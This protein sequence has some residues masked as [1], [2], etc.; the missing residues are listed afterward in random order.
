MNFLHAF[1]SACSFCSQSVIQ[2]SN[3]L[4]MFLYLTIIIILRMWIF[5]EQILYETEP[6]CQ[7][8]AIAAGWEGSK[9]DVI[10]L[11]IFGNTPDSQPY[12][13]QLLK[14]QRGYLKTFPSA[15]TRIENCWEILFYFARKRTLFLK[16]HLT[17]LFCRLLCT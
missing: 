13:F 12:N 10:K 6:C 7:I 11:V 16:M 5:Y 2:S 15:I 14:E 4:L 17:V 1:T 3:L 9:N 8:F